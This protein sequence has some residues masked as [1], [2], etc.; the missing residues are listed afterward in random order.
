MVVRSD[1]QGLYSFNNYS[2]QSESALFSEQKYIRY[3]I[4]KYHFDL[5]KQAF[6]QKFGVLKNSYENL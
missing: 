1:E 3:Y 6:D 5:V 2:V 4:L